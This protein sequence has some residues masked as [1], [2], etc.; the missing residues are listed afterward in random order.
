MEILLLKLLIVFCLVA[1]IRGAYKNRPDF[2]D[3]HSGWGYCFIS[4]IG[5]AGLAIV[6]SFVVFICLAAIQFVIEG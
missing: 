4:F 1:G 6:F 5:H 2:N 3:L